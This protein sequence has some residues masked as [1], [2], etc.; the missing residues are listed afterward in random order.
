M[1]TSIYIMAHKKFD[2]PKA[3]GYIPMQ[4][5][6]ALHEDLGI[7]RDD[8]GENISE[9]N[10][11]YSELTGI[12]NIWKND[13][14]SDVV[15]ICHYRRYFLENDMRT[16]LLPDRIESILYDFDIIVPKKEKVTPNV[17]EDYYKGHYGIDIEHLRDAVRKIYP[18]YS[19]AFDEAMDDDFIYKCNSQISGR[20]IFDEYCNFIF[21]VLFEVEK[22]SDVSEYDIYQKRLYGFL[23]ERLMN[24][25]I[26]KNKLKAYEAEFATVAIRVEFSEI[27]DELIKLVSEEEYETA[28][29]KIKKYSDMYPGLF[30]ED[31]F[32]IKFYKLAK[33]IHFCY[34]ASRAETC[35]KNGDINGAIEWA[36]AAIKF[37]DEAD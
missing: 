11:Y 30:A 15:G 36:K 27:Y 29:E 10:P 17:R 9:K 32:D 33:S 2:F 7:I 12:Y 21:P 6:A 4:V 13:K 5:G 37:S 8:K 35:E 23:S 24:V 20:K 1:K 16:M 19:D 31:T 3:T 28:E 14:E 34:A 22:H 18:D 26:I 25:F